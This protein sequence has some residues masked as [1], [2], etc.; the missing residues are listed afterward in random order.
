MRK[1]QKSIVLRG[2]IILERKTKKKMNVRLNPHSEELLRQQLA[3]GPYHSP[4]EVIEHALEAL[5]QREHGASVPDLAQFDAALDAL[6]EGS[7]KM[8]IL[9]REASTRAGIYRDHN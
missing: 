1:R 9:P 5:T 7:E 3:R 6:A 2:K 4:E 8:P